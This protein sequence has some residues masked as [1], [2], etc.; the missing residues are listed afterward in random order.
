MSRDG[1]RVPWRREREPHPL[2]DV[3]APTLMITVDLLEEGVGVMGVYV[4]GGGVY[5]LCMWGM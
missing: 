5:G 1:V 3:R 4:V 2:L